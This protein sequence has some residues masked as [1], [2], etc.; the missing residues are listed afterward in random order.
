M[1]SD[2]TL[3]IRRALMIALKAASAVTALVPASR[4]KGQTV[5]A[6]PVF[7]F[8]RMGAPSVIPRKGACVD[9]GDTI[10]AVHAFATGS[11]SVTA[12]DQAHQIGAAIAKALDGQRLTLDSGAIAA[13]RW[14][15]SQLLQDPEE[16]NAFHAVVSFR[17]RTLA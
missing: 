9:G 12:E 13:V 1:A 3:E 8:I 5:D 10:L 14:T 4:I 17:V 6:N 2:R 15:G 7:P 11:G 16:A